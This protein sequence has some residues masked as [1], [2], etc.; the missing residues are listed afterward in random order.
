[1]Q[2]V[3]RIQVYIFISENSEIRASALNCVDHWNVTFQASV[4]VKFCT[5]AELLLGFCNMT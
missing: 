3:L 4:C 5:P 1:M 2:I